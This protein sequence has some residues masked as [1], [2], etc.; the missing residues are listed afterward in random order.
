MLSVLKS[1]SRNLLESSGPVQV[2]NGI[3]LRL[4][5]NKDVFVFVCRMEWNVLLGIQKFL[6]LP[7]RNVLYRE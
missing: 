6:G 2:S 7:K 5:S 4:P 1:G 3:A